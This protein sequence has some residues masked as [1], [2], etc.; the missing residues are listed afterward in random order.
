MQ[1]FHRQYATKDLVEAP[2]IASAPFSF[3]HAASLVPANQC[4][5]LSQLHSAV[6]EQG[7]VLSMFAAYFHI[8]RLSHTFIIRS[9]AHLPSMT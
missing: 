8:Y 5:S 3:Q 4:D 9:I 1:P 7:N 2:G 6:D